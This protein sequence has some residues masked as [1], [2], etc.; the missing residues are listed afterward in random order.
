MEPNMK[1][2][3]IIL[4]ALLSTIMHANCYAGCNCDVW[5]DRDGYC[6][7]YV[8]TK[9]PTFPIPNNIAEIKALNNKEIAEVTEGDVAVFDLGNYWHVA[10]V[11]KVHLNTQ[12]KATAIDISEMNFG[13]QLSFQEFISK[14]RPKNESEWKRAL[15]CG[16]TDRFD[17]T[18]LRRNVALNTVKQIWSPEAVVSE[19][20][21]GR[22]GNAVVE[23]VRE[24]L[25]RFIVFTGREL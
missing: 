15:C 2:T 25:N 14:W 13:G 9:V 16:V 23:K 20:V 24:V 19:G 1:L 12:G 7:D 5:M 3:P 8:K 17:Q 4:A 18:S 11:E 6:V 22:F 21:S 10:Y